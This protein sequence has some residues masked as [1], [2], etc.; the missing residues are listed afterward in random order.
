MIR[1]AARLESDRA[2]RYLVQLCKH[3]AHKVPARYEPAPPARGGKRHGAEGAE[4]DS[5]A[6]TVDFPWGVCRLLSRPGSLEMTC[7]AAEPE[8]L[9]RIEHVVTDHVERFAWRDK[10]RLDWRPA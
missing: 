1:S 9:R 2:G 5:L 3:F 8:A 7:E 10:P 4:A 6:G